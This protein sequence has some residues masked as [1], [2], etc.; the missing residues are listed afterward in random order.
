MMW[1]LAGAAVV[2]WFAGWG[3]RRHAEQLRRD[4]LVMY[5][6]AESLVRLASV[7]REDGTRAYAEAGDALR[8]ATA[9]MQEWSA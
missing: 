1:L 3:E 7:Y 8:N 5:D 4:A 2:W 9:R 6:E